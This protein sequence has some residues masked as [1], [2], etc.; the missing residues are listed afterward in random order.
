MS[1]SVTLSFHQRLIAGAC[2]SQSPP[3]HL[4]EVDLCISNVVGFTKEDRTKSEEVQHEKQCAAITKADT[5]L[6]NYTRFCVTPLQQQLLNLVFDGVHRIQREYCVKGSN[7]R[8][9]YLK[10]VPCL[11]SVVQD[12]LNPCTKDLQ[13]MVEEVTEAQWIRRSNY[14][15]CAYHRVGSCFSRQ[16]ERSCGRE[17][18]DFSKDLIRKLVSRIPDIRCKDLTTRSPICQEL[19]SFGTDPKGGQSTSVINKLVRT[20]TSS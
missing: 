19:P 11:R 5:C 13:L 10:H 3:C 1:L 15:C 4:F 6:R 17:T 12:P 9:S 20:Y 14:A 16:V 2:Q 7:L 18:A 8:E